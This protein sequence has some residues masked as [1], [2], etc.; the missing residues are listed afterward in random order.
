MEYY[1][2]TNVLNIKFQNLK[3]IFPKMKINSKVN[4]LDA[5]KI[6][7]FFNKVKISIAQKSLHALQTIL[8]EGFRLNFY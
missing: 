5:I 7:S 1:N 6:T 3:L 4:E 8:I 2:V